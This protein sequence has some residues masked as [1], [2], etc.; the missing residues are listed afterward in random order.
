MYWFNLN[1]FSYLSVTRIQ[2]IAIELA[3]NRRGLNNCHYQNKVEPAKHEVDDSAEETVSVEE[4]ND[5][6]PSKENFCEKNDK[7]VENV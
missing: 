4:R 7:D 5:A 1:L 6:L 3:R 2:F